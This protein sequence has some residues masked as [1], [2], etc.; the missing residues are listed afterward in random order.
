L[1]A[2]SP[3]QIHAPPDTALARFAEKMDAAKRAPAWYEPARIEAIADQGG[4][5]RR[6]Y[7]IKSAFGTYCVTLDS[8]Q[9]PNGQDRM[10]VSATPK[11]TTCPRELPMR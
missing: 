1:R 5:G 6:M 8:Q 7:K 9:S 2:A 11:V 10:S 3:S 4:Y